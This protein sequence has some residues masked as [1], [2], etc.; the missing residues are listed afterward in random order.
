MSNLTSKT[1]C[2]L[3]IEKSSFYATWQAQPTTE[4][5]RNFLK[6]AIQEA[7]EWLDKRLVAHYQNE[8]DSI[9]QAVA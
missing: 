1:N 6:Y 9:I 8:L 7:G 2:E 3:F 5:R 4:N